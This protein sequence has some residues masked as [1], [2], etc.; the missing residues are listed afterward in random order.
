L[1]NSGLKSPIRS[2]PR[3]PKSDKWC[4]FALALRP[5]SAYVS[6]MS[7]CSK[8]FS[9]ALAV[10]LCACG[11]EQA[12]ARS[13]KQTA[14]PP[15]PSITMD[16]SGTPIIMQG[17]AIE[18]ARKRP[19]TADED[20]PKQRVERPITIRRGSS[21]YVPPPVPSPSGGPPSPTLLR[22]QVT[23]YQPP[24]INSFS[25]RVIGCN[26]SFTFNAGVGNNPP[27]RDAYVRSCAN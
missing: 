12:L 3:A 16:D 24:A 17:L 6:S 15:V 8:A 22:P 21:A 10:G 26:Q 25:D 1:V 5:N 19:G 18:R 14:D 20:Q 23:P 4:D 7:F 11:A 27:N 2:M 13:K 9:L